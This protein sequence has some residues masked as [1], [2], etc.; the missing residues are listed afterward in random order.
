MAPDGRSW[1]DY[2]ADWRPKIQALVYRLH[3]RHS[4]KDQDQCAVEAEL[5]VWE[6][7]AS[8]DKTKGLSLQSFTYRVM[9]EKIADYQVYVAKE[10]PIWGRN[11]NRVTEVS[12]VEFA[13]EGE[14]FQIADPAT[15][16]WE[17][18]VVVEFTIEE[19]L[20]MVEQLYG[21]ESLMLR[22]AKELLIDG[23]EPAFR[24]LA[25]KDRKR[26]REYI[27]NGLRPLLRRWLAQGETHG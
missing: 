17:E 15:E 6:A 5:G 11:Q 21:A 4:I 23:H 8:W 24:E 10:W 26:A 1:D 19:F 2:I 12:L 20:V 16:G 3:E 14:P 25:S 18:T 13:E 22:G 9:R 7:A 27:N